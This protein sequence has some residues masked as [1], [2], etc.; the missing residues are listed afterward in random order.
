MGEAGTGLGDAVGVMKREGAGTVG[1]GG[2]G[3][4][5]A[6]IVEAPPDVGDDGEARVAPGGTV[7]VGVAGIWVPVED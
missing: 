2:A 7:S 3:E 4:S 6:V 5:G 1:D